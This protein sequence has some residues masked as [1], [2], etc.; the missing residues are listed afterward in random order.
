MTS[1]GERLSPR[2]VTALVR[3][4][5]LNNFQSEAIAVSLGNVVRIPCCS[6]AALTGVV[7][8]TCGLNWVGPPWGAGPPRVPMVMPRFETKPLTLSLDGSAY[9]Q[10]AFSSFWITIGRG[11]RGGADSGLTVFHVFR[12]GVN[13]PTK[14]YCGS[15]SYP[16]N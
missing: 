15:G 1:S 16:S 10:V 7:G 9:F 2:K 14:P 3:G 4:I 5:V 12:S 8:R 6:P 13:R 11:V